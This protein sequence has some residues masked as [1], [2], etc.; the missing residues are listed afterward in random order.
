MTSSVKKPD[1]P[2]NPLPVPM[3]GLM[4]APAVIAMR[5]P[6]LAQEML[7][8][9]SYPAETMRATSEKA[10]AM[11]E[12]ILAAQISLAGS[13]AHFWFDVMLGKSPSRLTEK[14]VQQSFNAAAKPSSKRVRANYRRLSRNAKI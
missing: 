5:L 10:I 3:R 13:A 7:H 4:L 12:G 2:G 1:L 6:L 8:P 9:E 11:A 14:A